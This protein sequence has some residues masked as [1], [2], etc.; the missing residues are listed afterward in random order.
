MQSSLYLLPV[1]IKIGVWDAFGEVT[2]AFLN[3]ILS[4]L[5]RDDGGAAAGPRTHSSFA[6]LLIGEAPRAMLE[7]CARSELHLGEVLAAC[8]ESP[9]SFTPTCF[10]ADAWSWKESV[11][12]IRKL[13]PSWEGRSHTFQ[14]GVL[15]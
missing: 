11:F 15:E 14:Q 4:S 7:N 12:Q 10:S 13:G 2:Q 8:P 5:L 3:E 9:A 1:I 6:A